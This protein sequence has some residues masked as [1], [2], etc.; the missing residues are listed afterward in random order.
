M[1]L[2]LNLRIQ[3]MLW[4]VYGFDLESLEGFV[5]GVHL[6][7]GVELTRRVDTSFVLAYSSA[8]DTRYLQNV[9]MFFTILFDHQYV[10]FCVVI[11]RYR[12]EDYIPH[13]VI[14]ATRNI[15]FVSLLLRLY[16]SKYQNI[17]TLKR[18]QS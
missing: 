6:F 15:C 4:F 9:L 17:V 7:E 11:K 3:D 5:R 13:K 16:E 1:R 14:N 12:D 18:S 2:S 10:C 8:Y